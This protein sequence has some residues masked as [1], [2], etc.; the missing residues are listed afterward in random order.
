MNHDLQILSISGIDCYEHDG[1]AYLKLETVA[2]GLGFTETAASGNE[3][4]RWRT[5]K[6]YLTELGVAT[7][8]DGDL[9]DFIPE[10]I[11][12]RLAMKARNEAAESFQAKIADEVIPTIRKTGGYG[13]PQF[14]SLSPQMQVLINMELRQNKLEADQQAT[15]SVVMNT[16]NTF[17]A[18][19]SDEERWRDEMNRRVRQMCE[20]YGLNYH[21]TIGDMYALLERRAH[22]NLTTRQ[23][24][25]RERMRLG[26]AKYAQR[27]AVSKLVV[28]SQDDKLRFIYESIVREKAAQLAASRMYA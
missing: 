2:R 27:D 8:C 23:K 6:K 5:V 7:S 20:E 10:N 19:P 4:V 15:K 17:A 16:L 3:C 9:P 28:I 12:Y 24:N 1:V 11:F 22:V 13:N 21:T 14:A 25:L 26:G 18:P